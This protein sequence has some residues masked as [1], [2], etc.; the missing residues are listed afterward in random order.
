VTEQCEEVTDTVYISIQCPRRQLGSMSAE[1][2]DLPKW[3]EQCQSYIEGGDPDKVFGDRIDPQK[4]SVNSF[5][6]HV[7]VMCCFN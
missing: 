1:Y 5:L 7:R 6:V 4:V 3:F 2:E